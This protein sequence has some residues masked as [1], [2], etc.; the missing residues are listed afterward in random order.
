MSMMPGHMEISENASTPRKRQSSGM[1]SRKRSRSLPAVTSRRS[2]QL[3]AV[4]ENKE[5]TESESYENPIRRFCI[6]NK[7]IVNSSDANIDKRRD[8]SISICSSRRD[9]GISSCNGR[10]DS[11]LS[12]FSVGR[13]SVGQIGSMNDSQDSL[14]GDLMTCVSSIYRVAVLGSLG[15]GKSLLINQF[16]SSEPLGT[17]QECS[18]D[19]DADGVSIMVVLNEQETMLQFMDKQE[20]VTAATDILPEAYM[21]VYSCTCRVSFKAAVQICQHLKEHVQTDKSV[22][23]VANKADLA[24]RREVESDEGR[25]AA[26]RY[27]CKYIETSAALG[28]NVDELLVGVLSQIK[29]NLHPEYPPS[30]AAIRRRS[31]A[32]KTHPGLYRLFKSNLL[33]LFTKSSRKS[34]CENLYVI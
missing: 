22:I 9:S 23:L 6:T 11:T 4:N 8:S 26:F 3:R 33:G 19:S 1:A 25:R 31:S 16:T 28:L 34:S 14:D 15:V 32:I 13:C 2:S 17:L 21:V 27:E 29:L 30:G 20:D 10:R 12:N 7:G 5:D 24:R 18:S